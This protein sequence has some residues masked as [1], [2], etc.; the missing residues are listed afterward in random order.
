[1]GLF[2]VYVLDFVYVVRI[3]A[4]KLLRFTF[5]VMS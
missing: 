1:M 5:G 4:S 2:L 3:D